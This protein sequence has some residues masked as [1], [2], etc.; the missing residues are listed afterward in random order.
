MWAQRHGSCEL[1][2][3]GAIGTKAPAICITSLSVS[4]GLKESESTPVPCHT[5]LQ[6]SKFLLWNSLR[7]IA[8]GSAVSPYRS[9]FADCLAGAVPNSCPKLDLLWDNVIAGPWGTPRSTVLAQVPAC[10]FP[11][12]AGRAVY[13]MREPVIPVNELSTS[14]SGQVDCGETGESV[15][16]KCERPAAVA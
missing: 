12:A 15:E 7:F 5:D 3:E 14:G 1:G 11:D 2:P 8:V 9:E 16:A 13:R 10:R 4:C 6:I